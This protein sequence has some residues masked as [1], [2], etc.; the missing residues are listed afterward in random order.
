MSGS[1]NPLKFSLNSELRP[2]DAA[3]EDAEGAVVGFAEQFPDPYAQAEAVLRMARG[4]G[5][6]AAKPALREALEA[7]ASEIGGLEDLDETLHQLAEIASRS[8]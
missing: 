6:V 4:V 1:A 8:Y 7:K 3:L 2:H 5:R